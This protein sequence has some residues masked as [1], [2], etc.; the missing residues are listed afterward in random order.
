LFELDPD[1]QIVVCTAYSDYSWQQMS[2]KLGNSDRVVILK[3][4]FDTV[5]VLQLASTL[6]EKV[7]FCSRKQRRMSELE[8]SLCSAPNIWRPLMKICKPRSPAALATR[9]LGL[10]NEI[11]RLLATPAPRQARPC[12]AHLADH[13]PIHALGCWTPLEPL[14]EKQT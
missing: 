9:I 11:T 6:T 1:I 7:A 2:E 5:E 10:Q 14:I 4:P 3:K 13:L 8:N 12:F